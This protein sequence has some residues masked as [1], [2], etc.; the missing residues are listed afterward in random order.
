MYVYRAYQRD[1]SREGWW[2]DGD[3]RH[4][5]RITLSPGMLIYGLF[6]AITLGSGKVIAYRV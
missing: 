2:S 3:G 1:F 5:L 4:P 6:T